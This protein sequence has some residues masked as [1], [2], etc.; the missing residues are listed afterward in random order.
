MAFDHFRKEKVDVAVIETGM[1]GRLDSTNIITPVLSV[2]TNIGFDHTSFLGN[3]LE[4]IAG[5][6]AG[7]IKHQ[8][9]VIIGETQDILSVFSR[10]AAEME[11]PVYLAD[12]IYRLENNTPVVQDKQ[13]F[14]VFRNGK[15]HLRRLDTDLGGH[16]QKKNILT[17]LCAIDRVSDAFNISDIDIRQGLGNVI[18]LTGIRG[19]WEIIGQ[20]PRIIC[21]CGHNPQ[22]IMEVVKQIGQL[23]YRDLHFVFGMVD[24]KDPMPVLK[25]FPKKTVCYFTQANIPRAMDKD[26]LA[27]AGRKVGLE[28][29]TYP[30]PMLAL[31]AAKN[32]AGVDDLVVVGGSTFVVAEVL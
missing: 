12:Q 9:P 11:S 27:A 20:R 15:L 16:Y 7:I 21:D 32:A 19:R 5:E 1:G 25:L 6:K 23:S 14:H 2:I 10:K 13:T 31:E 28:G 24:D 26:K 30:D 22:G 8:V 3:T 29:E 17:A 18:K 4:L